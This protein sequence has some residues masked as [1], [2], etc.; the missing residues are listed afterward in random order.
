MARYKV[1]ALA[2]LPLWKGCESHGATIGGS[3]S[4]T[5]LPELSAG[6]AGQL[7]PLRRR[8]R[9]L[10]AGRAARKSPSS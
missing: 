9:G 1:Y 4:V 6:L 10:A 7:C 3:P 2:S 8:E 5:P